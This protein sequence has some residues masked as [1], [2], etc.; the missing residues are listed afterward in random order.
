[1]VSNM[2][3]LKKTDTI[4]WGEILPQSYPARYPALLASQYQ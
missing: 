2:P 3:S 1:M 4:S